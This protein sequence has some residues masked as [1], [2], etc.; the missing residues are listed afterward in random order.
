MP[1][2]AETHAG[3]DTRRRLSQSALHAFAVPSA[4]RPDAPHHDRRG[5]RRPR[6]ARGVGR[7]PRFAAHALLGQVIVFRASW[8]AMLRH[9][10]RATCTT[11]DVKQ[12]HA[13]I[14]AMTTAALDYPTVGEQ[15]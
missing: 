13:L 11:R 9:L 8:M 12:I 4:A 6:A 5:G 7:G 14:V 15:T 3:S 2:S 10:G 1:V